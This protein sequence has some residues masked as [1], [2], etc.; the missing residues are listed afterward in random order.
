MRSTKETAIN[1]ENNSLFI[2]KSSKLIAMG[3]PMSILKQNNIFEKVIAIKYDIPNNKL[4]MFDDYKV[5]IDDFYAKII[6]EQ[7]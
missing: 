5:A 2:R 7:A 3:I 4:S 6:E 1:D